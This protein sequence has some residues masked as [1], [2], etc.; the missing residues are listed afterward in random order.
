MSV[1]IDLTVYKI[2]DTEFEPLGVIENYTSLIWP[3]NFNS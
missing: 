1:N 2:T 3:D